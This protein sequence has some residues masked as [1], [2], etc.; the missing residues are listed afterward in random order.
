MSPWKKTRLRIEALLCRAGFWI[1]P[2]LPY[3]WLLTLSR[4]A[5]RCAYWLAHSQRR[6][7]LANLNLALGASYSELEKRRIACA[8]FQSFARTSLE[9][10]AGSRLTTDGFD[11]HFKLA[12][13][14]IELLK[15]LL[16]RKRG[17]IGLTFQIVN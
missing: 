5:G 14:S 1:F 10:L 13:G 2:R 15:E 4:M 16:A 6:I 17:L 7:A 8:S 3:S 11:R 12:P 9:T